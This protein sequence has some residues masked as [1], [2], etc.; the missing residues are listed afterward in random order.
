R[1]DILLFKTKNSFETSKKFKKDY[2]YLDE[3]AADL[4]LERG[5]KTV[6]IDYLS[7]ERFG[8]KDCA[9][10]KRLLP[11]IPIIE[12]LVLKDVDEGEYL[13]C[14]LPLKVKGAEAAPARAI[15]LKR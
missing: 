7:I 5:V 9:L 8:S 2:V 3:D 13:L 14:C 4:L 1:G 11:K 6:G 15:L 10:H 12:G